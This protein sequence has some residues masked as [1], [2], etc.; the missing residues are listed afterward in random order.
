VINHF[1]IQH[2][3]VNTNF[4]LS[5]RSDLKFYSFV[6]VVVVGVVGLEAARLPFHV[7]CSAEQRSEKGK[8]F[9]PVF[10]PLMRAHEEFFNKKVELP[11]VS[12]HHWGLCLQ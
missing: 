1:K 8:V 4:T 5:A 6:V 9:L 3:V 11:L 10:A 12:R 7:F 2:I